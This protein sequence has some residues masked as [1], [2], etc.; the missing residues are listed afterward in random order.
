[1]QQNKKLYRAVESCM[2]F[3]PVT[4]KGKIA[5]KHILRLLRKSY[6][7]WE[8]WILKIE[9]ARCRVSALGRST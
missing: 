5:V 7:N 1:M 3:M 2:E 8:P 6:R 9:P 4:Y